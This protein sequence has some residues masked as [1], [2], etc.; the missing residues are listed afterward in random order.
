MKRIFVNVLACTCIVQLALIAIAIIFEGVSIQKI[1]GGSI[2]IRYFLQILAIN[3][4]LNCGLFFT[5]KFESKFIIF[6]YLLDL[7]FISVVL[8]VYGAIF[9]IFTTKR[10]LFVVIGLVVY[11]LGLLTDMVRTR[12]DAK[13]MNELIKKRKEK[14]ANSVT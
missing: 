7:S 11:L 2:Q 12:E 4:V 3:T 9:D 6:E 13:E 10:W 5:H 14:N 1:A 8:L